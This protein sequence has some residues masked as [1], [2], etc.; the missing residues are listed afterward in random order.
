MVNPLIRNLF[1][2]V[3]ATVILWLTGCVS[4]GGF[5]TAQTAPE[6]ERN[7]TSAMGVSTTTGPAHD[8]ELTDEDGQPHT[9]D[10]IS[11]MPAAPV[12]M[13]Y[14]GRLAFTPLEG[15]EFELAVQN[16]MLHPFGFGFGAGT[17]IKYQF[18]GDRDTRVAMATAIRAFGHAH[19]VGNGGGSSSF[20]TGQLQARLI[21]SIH[22]D[23]WSAARTGFAF[24]VA[25]KLIAEHVGH[26]LSPPQ[27]PTYSGSAQTLLAGASVGPAWNSADGDAFYLELSVLVADSSGHPWE[28]D[29]RF[30]F[31]PR[32]THHVRV[33]LGVGVSGFPLA[34]EEQDWSDDDF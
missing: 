20:V 3:V 18:L 21:T 12:Q 31:L 1:R 29:N 17:G 26:H 23:D 25:P 5:E 7:V 16:A 33:M 32:S 8:Y 10:V 19:A 9:G 24:V 22:N 11:R 30:A 6:G 13:E 34:A 14:M 4:S 27:P 28:A 15:L 2:F